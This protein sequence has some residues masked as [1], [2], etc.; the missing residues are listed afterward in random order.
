[1]T[2]LGIGE[3]QWTP[4]LNY[5]HHL[6]FAKWKAFWSCVGVRDSPSVTDGE[7]AFSKAVSAPT[8]AP[9]HHAAQEH[10]TQQQDV[11][12]PPHLKVRPQASPSPLVLWPEPHCKLFWQTRNYSVML[13]EGHI[14][15]TASLFGFGL[16]PN[17]N[18]KWIISSIRLSLLASWRGI[19]LLWDLALL[20]TVWLSEEMMKKLIIQTAQITNQTEFSFWKAYSVWDNYLWYLLLTIKVLTKSYFQNKG[21]WIN[22]LV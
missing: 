21:S 11:W 2:H 20:R 12:S 18:H 1:M 4:L 14:A 5:H 15:P 22:G 8:W 9:V 19:A 3:S 13:I 17:M 6:S 7:Q 10:K 16:L